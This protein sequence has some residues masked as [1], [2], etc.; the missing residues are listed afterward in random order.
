MKYNEFELI[1]FANFIMN[2]RLIS[3]QT[4]DVGHNEVMAWL[5]IRKPQE[6]VRRIR[7][8]KIDLLFNDENE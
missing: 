5:E 2:R 8:M 1:D 3:N 7:E 4:G 6:F